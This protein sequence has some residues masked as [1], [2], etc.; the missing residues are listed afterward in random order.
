MANPLRRLGSGR[1]AVLLFD[2]ATTALANVIVVIAASRSLNGGALDSFSLAQ[3]V[4][5]M[6]TQSV[7]T[8]IWSPALAAQRQ[9]GKARIPLKWVAMLAPSIAVIMALGMMI[10]IPR[11]GTELVKWFAVLALCGTVLLAQDGLRSVLLSREQSVGALVSDSVTLAAITIGA[12]SGQIPSSTTAILIFWSL[13]IGCGFLVGLVYLARRRDAVTLPPQ[14]LAH[15]WRIGRWGALDATFSSIATLLPFFVATLYVSN[16]SAGPY[17]ILQTAMG[18]L[19]IIY[20]TIL[21]AFGLDSWQS[22]TRAGLRQLNR[23]AIRLTVILCLL[24]VAYVV[25]G[26]PLMIYVSQ[27]S[28][29]DLLRIALIVGITG[30]LSTSA[31]PINAATL[32]LGYQRFGAMIRFTVVILAVLVSIP[33]SVNHIVP[34]RDPIGTSMLITATITALGWVVSY[35]VA[36]TREMR[37]PSRAMTETADDEPLIVGKRH[38]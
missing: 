33:W 36:Y 37:R 21:T 15:A 17:R 23:R 32:A 28:H 30:M 35:C 7:R 31:A 11:N 22:A 24:V 16:T 8:A 13:S 26:I 29:P 38:A 20:T 3:L 5:V 1:N 19:N 6:L 18:P 10:L 34:R 4:L 9:T 2:T 12:V 25:V 27:I 14:S